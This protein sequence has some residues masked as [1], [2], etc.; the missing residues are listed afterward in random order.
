MS[1]SN[2]AEHSYSMLVFLPVLFCMILMKRQKSLVLVYYTMSVNINNLI[3]P[4]SHPIA[5]YTP[6]S[7]NISWLINIL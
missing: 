2:V 7:R 5:K 3:D 4:D 1:N 6:H